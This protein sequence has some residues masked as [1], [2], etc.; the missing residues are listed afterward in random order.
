MA[1]KDEQRR[2]LMNNLGLDSNASF[3]PGLSGMG[4]VGSVYTPTSGV[5]IGGSGTQLGYQ[6][7]SDKGNPNKYRVGDYVSTPTGW[8][9]VE[10]SPTDIINK[11]ITSTALSRQG[12]SVSD[13]F[14]AGKSAALAFN[15][16][17]TSSVNLLD[18]AGSATTSQMMSKSLP[19]RLL[20]TA[21]NFLGSLNDAG[22]RKLDEYL[23]QDFNYDIAGEFKRGADGKLVFTAD[24]KKMEGAGSE[25]GSEVLSAQ[26]T[27]NT[28]VEMLSDNSLDITVT[29]I[30]AQSDNY[31]DLLSKI[32]DAYSGMTKEQANEVVDK[33]TGKTRLQDIANLVKYA[34]SQFMYNV[35]VVRDLKSKAPTAS[36]ESLNIA[37]D[38][39][40]IGYLSEDVLKDTTIKVYDDTNNLVDVNAKEY[41]D[42]IAS[43]SK[44][45]RHNYMSSLGNRIEDSNIPDNE[46]AVLYAQSMA[47]YA[48]SDSDG[49]YKGMYQ[50]GFLDSI[51]SNAE[52]LTGQ[53][54]NTYF[55]GTELSTFRT[56][57]F[58]SGVFNLGTTLGAV[59]ALTGV[60]NLFEKGMRSLT[61]KLS[62]WA[63]TSM[64]SAVES[65][66]NATRI[67]ELA[68][69][70]GKTA[71]QLGYQ[72]GADV[73]YD[74]AKLLPYALTGNLTEYDFLTELGS[75]FA[76]DMI[77]TYGPGRMADAI[78]SQKFE[79][80][81]LIENTK[82]G[83]VEYK[84]MRDVKL[85][86]NIKVLLDE[87]GSRD[88]KMVE[89]TGDEIAKR[90]A[91]TIDKLTDN[92]ATIRTQELWFDKNA[93]M[94][95][96]AI[97]V[98]KVADKYQ[99]Q[100]MLRY[101]GDI[102]QVTSDTLRD[103]LNKR[104][105]GS[106]WDKMSETL[107]E[108]GKSIKDFSKADWN[109][110]KAVTNETRFLG[111]NAGDKE[112][113][114]KIKKFY[115]EGKTG[116]TKERA[117]QL[118]KL[119]QSM[120]D[121]VSHVLDFYVE[122]GL[123]T[124]KQVDE[125]RNA[126]G[127]EGGTYLPMYMAKGSSIG[128]DISQ[129][130]ALYKR[131]R[132]ENALIA[133]KDLDNPLN[134]MARY[135]NNAMR[136]VAM[137]D[138]AIAIREAA[139]LAGVGIRVV[140]DSGNSLKDVK[141]LKKYSSDFDKI[142]KAIIRD[143]NSK[144]PSLKKW[145]ETNSGFVMR[146]R[147]LKSAQELERLQNETKELRR[148]RR[149]M[150]AR[151]NP[152]LK[153]IAGWERN[154]VKNNKER[155]RLTDDIK[156][157]AENVMNRAQKAHVGSDAKLDI[158]TYLNVQFTNSLKV[159]LRSENM[160]G[161]VQNELNKA[162]DLANPWI[163]PRAVI[164]RRAEGAAVKFRKKVRDDI[165]EQQK[166][167]TNKKGINADKVNSLADK[168]MDKI[169]QK[170]T[171]DRK[172][173]ATFIDEEGMPTRMLDNYGDDNS[174]RYMVDGKEQRFVLSGTG[175]KELVQEFRAPE[176]ITPKTTSQKVRNR[177]LDT[178][179]KIAQG[180]RY[181]TTAWN[182]LRAPMNVT[183]DWARGIV[184]T[185]GQILISPKKFFNDLASSYG[186]DKDT[187]DK[188]QNGLMLAQGAIKESTLT[189][190]LQMPAKNREK[191]MVR[192]M[193]EPDGNAFIK[194][195]Y[196]IKAKDFGKALSAVQD[197]G[198]S[199]VRKRAMDTAYYREL[200]DAQSRGVKLDDAIKQATEAAY[201][202]GREATMNFFRRGTL[203]TKF[204]QQTPYLTQRFA[205]IES[206]K[207]TY[208]NDPIG[209]ERAL[210]ASVSA[211]T[212]LIAIALSN[213]ESRKKY[214]LLTE[215]DRAN[216]I[217][218]PL[219]TGMIMTIP[220]DDA[221]AAFLTPYRR[222][223]EGLNGLDPEAFYLC[224]AEGL[225]ALSPMDLSGFS[226]GDGFNVV[227]GL[228]R[229]TSEFM[230]TWAQPFIEAWRGRDLYYGSTISVDS[231]Y[232][233]ALYDNWTP[234]PGELTT[235][236]KNSQTLALVADR[237]GI[238][239]WILQNFVSEYGGSIS[240]YMLNTIDKIAGATEDAQGG[241]EW[242]DTI[243]K[244]FTGSDSDQAANSFYEA[245]NQLKVEKKKVQNEIKTITARINGAAYNEK[246]ELIKERQKKI[247]EYGL[248]VTDVLNQYL[249]AFEITGG[250]SKKQANQ[251]WYLYKLYDEQAN[252]DMYMDTTTGQYFTD[253]A[254]A[255]NNKQAV[256]LAAG[257]GLDTLIKGPVNDYYDSYAEQAFKNTSYGDTYEY[258][259]N[260]EEVLTANKINRYNMFN[261][262]NNMTSAQKKQWKSAWNTKVVKALAPYVE[263][264]GIDNLLDQ[265]KVVDYLD[266][267]IF[268]SNPWQTKDYLKKI[269]G[270][271]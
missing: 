77:A 231:E 6:V 39:S 237:T 90:R 212:S 205:S 252:Q 196:D 173:E 187:V 35:S 41:L 72:V 184:T 59:K 250:L 271:N 257:S 115:K 86:D 88:V 29:P 78:G 101:A 265:R 225:A 242:S 268:V 120:H 47:L 159:A 73:I 130:R 154:I 33:D 129:D 128:D 188:I 238:P 172:T 210:T 34:E 193:L 181:M 160:V 21:A 99:Y 169:T 247:T 108:T 68:K 109:Y 142:H 131:V 76:M 269:F 100:K 22:Q 158:R 26:D 253:K 267:V 52:I 155:L 49:E 233:G 144:Y 69:L 104:E 16:L 135:V 246:A 156:R 232:T 103:F 190:S 7:E 248:K 261:G 213:E 227:R 139:S 203:V 175:A 229:L 113:E 83:K 221:M 121:V 214:F 64:K 127:Y 147:A 194:F 223:V 239:Q 91:E 42:S 141:N 153:K 258:I 98:R 201:F 12:L 228:E 161:K 107:R 163:D 15:G 84:R 14:E 165:A 211:Y 13:W 95:K 57:E 245:I 71:T 152:D 110:I 45:E 94:G 38:V 236:G 134:S 162:V 118:D 262:Y 66:G 19:T 114:A 23:N 62:Q 125:L 266:E 112:A 215:Y 56:N 105:V 226:E 199:F 243:F 80:R 224:F 200:S 119:M 74:T 124:K 249:S 87:T 167:N 206:L 96:L 240:E 1:T 89:V 11:Y 180:K 31:K 244:A 151:K 146:S 189:A 230:P 137:N 218:I 140:N 171:G 46:K 204:A 145:Q 18:F 85:D 270:G 148:L 102:R 170:I 36:D 58:Y 97:Q 220:L 179:N 37:I 3:K 183:R 122:K 55:G 177:I 92:S 197:A 43:K 255:W 70:S 192:A 166:E 27:S 209:M 32:S 251:A 241:K 136:A 259:A 235:R 256:S 25:S 8:S 106:S 2:E 186:Y 5:A 217:I 93:A 126:P 40:K 260:I 198:E 191:A 20:W 116:V 216:N 60:T 63:G 168:V 30:F 4:A 133:L 50:K 111:K 207:Y 150:K 75:D 48:A 202:A 234:T 51:G 219:D 28:N 157:Y 123:M 185:G 117:K 138:R 24:Y 53:T 164:R 79:Y 195:A 17:P 44:I 222:M 208:L 9:I 67:R 82:T 65:A 143:V 61:P 263:E 182:W 10:N 254:K 81:V 178:G 174:I 264:V 132:N 176:F 54:W 149:N